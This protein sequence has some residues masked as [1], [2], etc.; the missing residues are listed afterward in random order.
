MY[1]RNI[2]NGGVVNEHVKTIF[3]SHS[4]CPPMACQESPDFFDFTEID[5]SYCEHHF[6][7]A[8]S[9]SLIPS[10]TPTSFGKALSEM[11]ASLSL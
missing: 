7:N 3:V 6:P 11:A 10:L 1:N 5:F 9:A 2:R 4:I 8:R